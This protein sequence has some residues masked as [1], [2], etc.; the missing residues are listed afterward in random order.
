ME[1]PK[2]AYK[3]PYMALYRLYIGYNKAILGP[4]WGLYMGVI[5]GGHIWGGYMG[6]I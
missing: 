1:R 3:W 2:I 4:I 5:Y 6:V